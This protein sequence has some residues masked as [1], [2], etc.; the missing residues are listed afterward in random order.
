M[1]AIL[2]GV[3][4][5]DFQTARQLAHQLKG[6]G[7]AYGFPEI[8]AAGAAIELAAKDSD[9]CEILTQLT[10]LSDHLD[11]VATKACGIPAVLNGAA[12]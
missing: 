4:G 3:E 2:A 12:E 1:R 11:R 7:G 9:G 5:H 10:A 8:S 6:T